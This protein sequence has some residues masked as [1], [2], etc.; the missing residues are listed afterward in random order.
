MPAARPMPDKITD[1]MSGTT[2][3]GLEFTDMTIA[4]AVSHIAARPADAPFGFIVTPN[5]EHLVRLARDP[6]PTAVY[7]RAL[8]RVMDS[9]VVLGAATLL[10]LPKPS[11]VPGGDLTVE[12]L[13]KHLRPGDRITVI[14]L[15]PKDLPLLRERFPAN[16]IAHHS[17]PLGFERDGEA[18][19]QTV[20]FVEAN[21]ARYYIFACGMPR[22]ELLGD[23]LATRGNLRGT[24]LCVGSALES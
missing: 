14:G 22:Q 16:P 7:R 19:R 6:V 21:P 10:D 5:A 8:L 13:T 1:A 2:L 15:W 20:A 12:L 11:L 24:A 9:H 4:E 3:L 17:P 23:R 18:F